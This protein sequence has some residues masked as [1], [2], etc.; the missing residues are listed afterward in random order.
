[1]IPEK[2]AYEIAMSN[3]VRVME[4]DSNGRLIESG[5]DIL[6]AEA[7]FLSRRRRG[8]CSVAA[9]SSVT[10]VMSADG[11]LGCNDGVG[12]VMDSLQVT[13]TLRAREYSAMCVYVTLQS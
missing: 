8:V 1:M 11:L 6:E 12:G 9:I 10:P 2:D 4:G 3:R 13:A 5:L 7:I